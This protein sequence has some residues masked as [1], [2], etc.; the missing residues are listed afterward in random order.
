VWNKIGIFLLLFASPAF[1]ADVP[2]SALPPAT[3][4]SGADVVP[5]VQ[6]ATTKKASFTVQKSLWDSYYQ[7][8]N[9]DLTAISALAGT[10]TIYYRSAAN[11]WSAVTIGT[12]LSFSGATLSATGAFTAGNLTDA[13]TDGIT[14]TGGTNAVNGSG[15]SLS[16]HVSDSTHNGYLS[17]TDWSTF[18]GKLSGNQTITLSGDVTGS[19]T[20]AITSTIANSAVTYAKMQNVSASSKLLGSSATGSGAPPSEITVGSG[21]TMTGS[22]L[23]SSGGGGTPG[24]SNTQVQYNNSSAFG[25]ITNATSDGTTE[26]LTSPKIVTNIKDT[27]ANTLLGITATGTAVNNLTIANAASGNGP[28][29]GSSGSG[30]DIDVNMVPKGAG[31]INLSNSST[32]FVTLRMQSGSGK[33]W[34]I[35][36]NGTV[37]LFLPHHISFYNG[38]DGNLPLDIFQGEI[39]TNAS[40][41]FGWW[42]NGSNAGTGTF[43][44]GLAR[45]ATGV[46]EVNNGTMGTFRDIKTRYHYTSVTNDASQAGAIGEYVSSLIASG[47][48][49]SLTNATAA[50]V[51]SISLTAGDWDVRGNVN[52]TE[53]TS[54]VTARSAGI[55]TTSATL[56]TDGSEGYC[57]VQSTV[58]S[59]TNTITLPAKRISLSTT[60]TV[61]LVGQATF[62]A[63]TCAGFGTLTARR[64]R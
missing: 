35:I 2:I 45:N 31:N 24:G 17:L 41:S 42:S 3:T 14:V 59:E 20:T 43:D 32:S 46:V 49:V 11:V 58:T 4:V 48:A 9:S 22:T 21:L 56:P 10:H 12:G 64:T 18:N 34:D 1:G 37:G 30:T 61:Y 38:T 36:S 33:Q 53:T 52:F 57:G 19:G 47:S 63:G 39:G 6:S 54:T 25:G 13:G 62:S 28:T 26:T 7:P 16:Q 27:N 29:I 55:S 23:S 8:L 15:T 60:T 40:S 51:T 50:N 5:I 44:T